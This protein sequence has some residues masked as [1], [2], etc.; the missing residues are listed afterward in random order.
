MKASRRIQL[1]KKRRRK[2]LLQ[3]NPKN[4]P[5]HHNAAGHHTIETDA[6]G[7]DPGHALQH[8]GGEAHA[9]DHGHTAQTG[10]GGEIGTLE[11]VTEGALRRPGTDTVT[12]ADM[13]PHLHHGTAAALRLIPAG[14]AALHPMHHAIAAGVQALGDAPPP[15]A[16]L[17]QTKNKNLL[18]NKK[19]LIK[20]FVPCLWTI[21]ISTRSTLLLF[22]WFSISPRAP[23]GISSRVV[24]SSR[25]R[26]TS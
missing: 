2:R 22:V 25:K 20:D 23:K 21:E 17:A 7:T 3:Q 9:R 26:S 14:D 16:P 10:T 24:L 19:K 6:P 12:V 13:V 18:W 1:L 15:G 4:P 11:T 8:P 5:N